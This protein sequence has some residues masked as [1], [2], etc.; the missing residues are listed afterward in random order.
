[1]TW[2]GEDSYDEILLAFVK[3]NH[4]E[5]GTWDGQVIECFQK[6]DGLWEPFEQVEYIR[7]SEIDKDWE[8]TS[9]RLESCTHQFVVGITSE[10]HAEWLKEWPKQ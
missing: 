2:N 1:M 6:S 3:R 10:I 9:E 4:Y 8:A 7:G 5:V